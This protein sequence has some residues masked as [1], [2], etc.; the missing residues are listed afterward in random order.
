MMKSIRSS[1]WAESCGHSGAATAPTPADL[2]REAERDYV[3]LARRSS[4]FDDELL[5]DLTRI[6][7]Q[8]YA[9]IA[10]LAYRQALAG[11]GLAADANKQPLLFPKEN[12]SNG[13]VATVDVIYPA[14]PQFLLMGPTYARRWSRR[15]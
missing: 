8:R 3:S 13:C 2:L 7:G 10:A 5:S 1:S 15:P 14:A 11:C 6:G 4:T 12:S 9:Q